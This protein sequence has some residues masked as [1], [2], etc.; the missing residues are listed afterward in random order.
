[1]VKKRRQHRQELP[2][3]RVDKGKGLIRKG[4]GINKVAAAPAAAAAAAVPVAAGSRRS[5]RQ[6]QTRF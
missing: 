5:V 2:R 4:K 3:E 6:G 1:L